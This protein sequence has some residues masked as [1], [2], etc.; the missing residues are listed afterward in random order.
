MTTYR[1]P[2]PIPDSV[3]EEY[4]Q[5]TKRHELMIQHC[6][7]CSKHIF[8]PR[9]I[10][11]FC[12]SPHLEWVKASGRGRVY[13]YTVIVQANQPGFRGEEPYIYAVVELDEGPHMFTN[14]VD[15]PTEDCKVDMPVT[16]VFDDVTPEITLPKFR[17][18]E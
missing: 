16:V 10:C 9:A 2:I 4:W 15:C 1:K 14:I 5:G 11:P 13:S 18:A 6:K 12:L 3:S 7:L 8:Y 17:P